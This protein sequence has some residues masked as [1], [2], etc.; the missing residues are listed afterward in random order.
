MEANF[1]RFLGLELSELLP[2][3]R[4][5]KV[6]GPSE[7]VLVLSLHG[8]GRTTQL[9]LRPAKT[10]G[11]LFAAA[12][13]PAN[14]P[15]P[16][17]F[18]M[19]LRKRL[20][21]RRLL[22]ARLDWA[23]LRLAF[24]LSP[25]DLPQAGNW[26]VLDLRAGLSLDHGFA[27]PSEPHWPALAQVLDDPEIWRAHP[28]LTPPLRKRLAAL[29]PPEAEALLRALASGRADGFFLPPGGPPSVWELPGSERFPTA[30]EAARAHGQRT[31]FPQLALAE[32]R[33]TLDA[34]AQ[35]EKKRKRQLALLDAD[36]ARHA[37]LA[38]LSTAAEALQIALS[39]LAATPR[40][41]SI[42]LEHPAHGP[43]D[44]PLD[45]RLTPAENMARL[46]AQAA[47]GRRG[48]EHVARRRRQLGAGLPEPA[49]VAAPGRAK[50]PA[51]PLV[52][53]RFQGLAVALFR[54]T[55]GFLVLRGKS[56]QANHDMLSRAASP[57]DLWLHAAG[58]PSAH[59]ILKRD[60]PDQP[61]P[62]QS[63]V[64]AATL[65]AL[66][67]WRKDDAKAEVLLAKVKDVRKVKGAAIGSVAV[68]QVERT[69]VV[70]VDPELEARLAVR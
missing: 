13:R 59:V 11:L 67:S 1:F 8:Q 2:G 23:N 16:P 61:V 57:F 38:A 15:A 65:C 52:P 18:V 31:L 19:W 21:G 28:Q 41:A 30:L 66:K 14:P 43:V 42:S 29:P 33:E 50:P 4:I 5:E 6:H 22:E 60:Y 68:D 56:S 3:Q 9:I 64:E 34:A 24:A 58:G 54:T 37:K 39:G 48:L 12:E 35:A 47:K 53:K 63:L 70:D 17:A 27:V 25:R 69:L 62:E 51:P 55:D 46:F 40:A 49:T 20:T 45:P 7:G 10:A 32:Q 44:V 26:L 36:A